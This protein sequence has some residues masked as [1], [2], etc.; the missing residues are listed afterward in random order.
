MAAPVVAGAARVAAMAARAAALKNG[1]RLAAKRS[2]KLENME[3]ETLADVMGHV[4]GAAAGMKYDLTL[5]GDAQ[6]RQRLQ[7]L[8]RKSQGKVMRKALRDGAKI[9]AD[10]ARNRVPI[11]TGELL[12]SIKVRALPRSRTG[13]GSR[14][15]VGEGLQ[16]GRATFAEYGTSRSAGTAFLYTSSDDKRRQ[17]LQRIAETVNKELARLDT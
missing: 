9:V 5:E 15:L 3:R 2:L 10:E 7:R 13:F 6:L 11:L 14:V 16:D 17:A 1:A 8:E 12:K 4:S